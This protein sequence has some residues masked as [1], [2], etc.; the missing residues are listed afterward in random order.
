MTKLQNII[1]YILIVVSLGLA[2]MVFNLNSNY[3][4]LKAVYQNQPPI[5]VIDWS[6][7]VK[8]DD[9]ER[10]A[11]YMEEVKSLMEE[12][13]TKN[14]IVLDSRYINAAPRDIIIGLNM[15]QQ[16]YENRKK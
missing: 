12:L 7:I 13:A 11:A 4:D 6:E 10:R 15:I 16:R 3:K 9:N 8:I 2:V 1:F 5:V 14:A